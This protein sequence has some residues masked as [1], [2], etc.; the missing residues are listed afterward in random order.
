MIR[1]SLKV[2][3][4]VLC[5]YIFIP[6]SVFADCPHCYEM[7]RVRVEFRDST[8]REVFYEFHEDL[9]ATFIDTDSAEVIRRTGNTMSE[10]PLDMIAL[11]D[12]VYR[13]EGITFAT[14][15][16]LIDSVAAFDVGRIVLLQ[17]TGMKAAGT[18]NVFD[19][20]LIDKL[21]QP[22]LGT[23][24]IDDGQLDR[25][26]FVNYNAGISD[27]ALARL[28][29]LQLP[30]HRQVSDA[31]L[32][33]FGSLMGRRA[34]T[35]EDWQ[36]AAIWV[37]KKSTDTLRAYATEIASLRELPALDS[38][39]QPLA[40]HTDLLLRCAA[41]FT[42]FARTQNA[43]NLRRA[44]ADI[45][46][47]TTILEQFQW[48]E[49]LSDRV[50]DLNTMARILNRGLGQPPVISDAALEKTEILVVRTYYD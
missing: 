6:S 31:Q 44:I 25:V 3:W 42:E 40:L 29:T 24:A 43:V 10:G 8:A 4:L 17:R 30:G 34:Q 2:A 41:M 15:P 50:T 28:A 9:T 38:L 39:L 49:S 37:G 35:W 23:F 21:K 47:D 33:L 26:V 5:I 7:V 32:D 11:I 27:S 19:R 16:E 13:F 22:P 14:A 20:A 36:H 48:D 18:I 12:H 45:V 1:V 46:A